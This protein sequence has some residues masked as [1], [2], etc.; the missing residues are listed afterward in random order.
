M[1]SHAATTVSDEQFVARAERFPTDT[2]DTKEAYL[3]RDIFHGLFPS[4]AAAETAVRSVA[5][6]PTPDP[7]SHPPFSQ[8]DTPRRLG[9]RLRSKRARRQHPHRRIRGH[10]RSVVEGEELEEG[11]RLYLFERVCRRTHTS[12]LEGG[13]GSRLNTRRA[14]SKRGG[15]TWK[16]RGGVMTSGAQPR[17]RGGYAADRSGTRRASSMDGSIEERERE[18]R[19]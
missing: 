18:I 1:K 6:H 9:L 5:L 3:I 15:K 2:P 7:H 17:E 10:P 13:C 14:G 19:G 8:M 4:D 11:H 16:E 12:Y